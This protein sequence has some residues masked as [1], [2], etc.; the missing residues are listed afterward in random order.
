MKTSIIIIL[1]VLLVFVIINNI[2][3][4]Q[5]IMKQEYEKEFKERQL[6]ST[7][8]LV[9]EQQRRVNLLKDTVKLLRD[10]NGFMNDYITMMN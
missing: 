5:T 7:E 6:R 2:K 4:K 9:I 10:Q 8:Q 3:Q 1:S